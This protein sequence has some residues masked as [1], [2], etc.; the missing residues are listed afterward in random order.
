MGLLFYWHVLLLT[1]CADCWAPEGFFFPQYFEAPP[2]TEARQTLPASFTVLTASSQ[3]PA[4]DAFASISPSF[5]LQAC[6][7]LY[8]L[9]D[10]GHCAH[11]G[12]SQEKQ[13]IVPDNYFAAQLHQD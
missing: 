3:P 7:L 4:A 13:G 5:R 8:T 2:H 6:L 12:V 11:E 9:Y 1:V 10:H